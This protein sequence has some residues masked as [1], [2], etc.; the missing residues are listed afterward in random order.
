MQLCVNAPF[1]T[2]FRR[3]AS[4]FSAVVVSAFFALPSNAQNNRPCVVEVADAP[5]VAIDSFAGDV[6]VNGRQLRSGQNLRLCPNDEIR[7]GQIGRV[8]IRFDAK[9]TVIRLDGNSRAKISADVFVRAGGPEKA[10][11]SLFSGILYFLSSVRQKFRVETPYIVAGIEGTEALVA[12]RPS[13]RLAITAVR[14]GV[15][16]AYSQQ[17]GPSSTLSVYAGEA[18]FTSANVEFQKASIANLPPPFRDL[19]IVSDSSVDWA[20]YYPPILLVPEANRSRVR[21]AVYLMHTGDYDRAEQ[22]LNAAAGTDP[23][24][25]AALRTIIAVGRNRL[26]EAQH[27][28]E[29]ALH[30]GQD[31]A[32]AHV[33]ASYER[34]ANGDLATALKFAEQAA[35]LAPEDPYAV[36]RLAELQMTIGDRVAA[37]NTAQRSLAFARTPLALFVSGLANLAAVDYATAEAQFTE[38][39]HLDRQAPLPRLGLG[40]AYIRQGKIAEGTWQIERALAHDPRRAAIRTWLGRAYY[41]EGLAIQSTNPDSPDQFIDPSYVGTK[42]RLGREYL[43]QGASE[44][45]VDQNAQAEAHHSRRDA[46][47]TWIGRTFFNDSLSRKAADQFRLAQK[48]DPQD[49]RPYLFSA[50]G[51]FSA[52]KIIQALD[53]A[54]EAEKRGAGRRVLRSERGLGEDAATRGAALGRIYDTLSFDQLAIVTGAKATDA[55]QGDPGAHRFLSDIYR[56][57]PDHNIA[58]TSELLR[59]QLLSPPSQTPVQPQL[60]E[61]RLALL[62]T[63]GPSRVAFAEF[64]PLFNSDGF[65]L[66]GSGLYGTQNTRA[67]EWAATGLHRNV[68]L[69]IGQFNYQTDGYHA[70]NDLEHDIFNVIGKVALT[71]EFTLFGEYR[72]R[73]SEGGDRRLNFDLNNFGPNFRGREERSVSHFGFHARPSANSDLIGVFTRGRTFVGGRDTQSFFGFPITIEAAEDQKAKSGQIQYMRNDGWLRSIIGGSY[74]ESEGAITGSVFGFPLPTIP[75][76]AEY[77]NGYAYFN[78]E[79]PARVTWTLGGS[80]VRHKQSTDVEQDVS[81]FHPKLGVSLELNEFITLRGSYLKTL[82]PNFVTEQTI[83]PTTIAGFSQLYDAFDGSVL[84]LAGGGIDFKTGHRIWFGAEAIKRWWNAPV[85]G[86][87][88]SETVEHVRRAYFSVALSQSLALSAEYI[89]E[90]SSSESVFD[91][92]EWQANSVP[93]TLSYFSDWGLFA[94]VR[95]EYVDHRFRNFGVTNEDTFTTVS[96]A[97]G[98]RFPKNKGI[99]SLEIQNLFD[100]EFNFQN[101]TIRPDL[102]A[103]PRYAPERTILSRGT[104]NF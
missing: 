81:E 100:N 84:E 16:D 66:D 53:D 20:V 47:D 78:V 10:D 41:D 73:E 34:Q 50:L 89:R 48:D 45:S 82:K 33:A 51:N 55:D 19:L 65:R 22:V 35:R 104:L 99:L 44:K 3:A 36:A 86:T 85:G 80:L 43:A 77:Y 103:A 101:R 31:Y 32:P 21:R 1:D 23:A 46:R 11:V 59:G 42:S 26:G 76:E 79:L 96:T 74:L 28:A 14:Q 70:N 27:W 4:V 64:A 72:K 91:F 93:V 30:S 92:D 54:I 58:R 75:L 7:T 24:T 49:P 62:D 97:L 13:D 37:L 18:A 57:R 17:E 90:K 9:R 95:A 87:L 38:A 83:E 2:L 56:T 63:T 102:S 12:T 98:Y 60:G 15:V 61:A 69:S 71:P 5:V 94:S 68:S 88:E 67:T 8:A 39:I 29:V 52:N 40:L 25:T 6:F